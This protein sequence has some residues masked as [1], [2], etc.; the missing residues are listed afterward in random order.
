VVLK[1]PFE[2]RTK[3]QFFVDVVNINLACCKKIS[4]DSIYLASVCVLS[5]KLILEYENINLGKSWKDVE[6][7]PI[8]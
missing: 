6:G 2:P 8:N 5:E 1:F 3:L 4:F 7:D